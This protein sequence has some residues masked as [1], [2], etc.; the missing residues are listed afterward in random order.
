MATI[1]INI[2]SANKVQVNLTNSR[3]IWGLRNFRNP[4]KAFEYA[5]GLVANGH[6]TNAFSAPAFNRLASLAGVLTP[7][8]VD[9]SGVG[10]TPAL[11]PSN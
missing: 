11:L 7:R 6:Q 9:K 10:T 8:A 4:Q 5:A 2:H 3:E 1:A